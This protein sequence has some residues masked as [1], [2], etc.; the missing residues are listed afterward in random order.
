[1]DTMKILME[2]VIRVGCKEINLAC[3]VKLCAWLTSMT[4]SPVRCRSGRHEN[5]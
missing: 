4:Q 5:T 3:F 1:M 2:A